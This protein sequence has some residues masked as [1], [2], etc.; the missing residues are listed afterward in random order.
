M[1]IG[2]GMHTRKLSIAKELMKQRQV[3]DVTFFSESQYHFVVT[4]ATD[5]GPW[6]TDH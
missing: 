2:V 4:L 5:H 1:V 3:Q 6:T